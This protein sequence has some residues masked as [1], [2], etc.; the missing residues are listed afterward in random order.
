MTI[1]LFLGAG[2]S[3]E[4]GMPL[5]W[6]LTAELRAWLTPD[7]LRNFNRTWKGQMGGGFPDAVIDDFVSILQTP[8]MH[9]E[10]MLGHLQTQYTRVGP[11]RQQYHGLYQWLVEAVYLILYFRHIKNEVYITTGLRY[12]EGIA[13]LCRE[14][15]P[16][17]IFTS[18]HDLLVECLCAQ[19]DLPLSF[20]F[21]D[22]AV[23]PLLDRKGNRLGDLPARVLKGDQ[24]EKSGMSFA[25]PGSATVNVLKI[26]GALDTFTYLEGKDLLKLEPQ[27]PGVIGIIRSLQA[28]NEQLHYFIDG[29]PMKVTNEIAYTDEDGEGQFLRRS[30]LAGAFKFDKRFSQ[31]IPELLLAQF[32]QQLNH[33][34]H[35]ICIGYG[36]GDVHLNDVLRHWLEFTAGRRME[37]V[38]PH[39]RTVPGFL[40]H[41]SPQVTL[42]DKTASDFLKRFALTPLTKRER[43][44]KTVRDANRKFQRYRRGFA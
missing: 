24:L 10:S 39:M 18:N 30:L 38:S 12:L 5:V 4:L 21:P 40:M 43:F 13:G 26:H 36:F 16:L 7:K 1:G 15:K 41:V 34:T 3:F 6:D 23:L 17:W 22:S 37:I 29:H 25:P 27:G 33:V 19:Y 44:C 42:H 31:V 35:L 8:G 20:G 32:R 9:Y 14:S 11:F 28:A 2:A